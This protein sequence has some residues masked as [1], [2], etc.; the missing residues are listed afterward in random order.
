M[1]KAEQLK[2]ILNSEEAGWCHPYEL[3]RSFARDFYTK[4][5]KLC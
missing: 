2:P 3:V 1:E 4:R 5:R